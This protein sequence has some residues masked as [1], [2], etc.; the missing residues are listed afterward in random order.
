MRSIFIYLLSLCKA[1]EAH[2][3]DAVRFFSL[4]MPN[5]KYCSADSANSFFSPLQTSNSCNIQHTALRA[6]AN[7][8]DTLRHE[9]IIGPTHSDDLHH[10]RRRLSPDTSIIHELK[11]HLNKG[12]L[13]PRF[14]L[15]AN[16]DGNNNTNLFTSATLFEIDVLYP[17][18]SVSEATSFSTNDFSSHVTDSTKLLVAD[19]VDSSSGAF[20]ILIVDEEKSLVSGII[21]KDKKLFKFEQ[22]QGGQA[23]VA[24][25][26]YVPHET[27]T[28]GTDDLEEDE[29]HHQHDH[30]TIVRTDHDDTEF[31]TT[32]K[33]L[34]IHNRNLYPTDTFPNAWSYQV[35]LYIEVDNGM[36]NNR[37][38][39]PVKI[40]N[41][42]A[43]LNALITA[44]SSI[45]EKEIDTH[46]KC[47]EGVSRSPSNEPKYITSSIVNLSLIQQ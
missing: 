7:S 31:A 18:P 3:N 14:T 32:A 12:I 41:T 22:V 28:C 35:D 13:Y 40:P 23:V 25:L 42:I 45:F 9:L 17:V 10:I 46:R 20:A 6:H 24:E 16:F 8:L 2:D 26:N 19:Q 43:Y 21:Q 4:T 44:V 36:I 30:E 11:N 15:T 38:T 27:W 37:D 29:S 34:G 1:Y 39:D 47:R 5:A 33:P